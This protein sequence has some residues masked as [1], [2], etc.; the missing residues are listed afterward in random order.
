M[1]VFSKKSISQIEIIDETFR[2]AIE[3]SVVPVSLEDKM[4]ILLKMV[5]AGIKKF[6]MGIGPS[7]MDLLRRCVDLQKLGS[8]PNDVRFVYIVLLNT[9]EHTKAKFQKNFSRDEL[10][11]IVF[12]FGMLELDSENDLFSRVLDEYEAIGMDRRIARVSIL[13][14]F[15]LNGSKD[16]ENVEDILRQVQYCLK[17]D[18]STIR[19]NDSTGKLNPD[20]TVK[21]FTMLNKEFPQVGFGLHTHNDNGL[22]L[23]NALKSIE[24]GCTIV[25]GSLA[26]FGNR[27]GITDLFLLVKILKDLEYNIGKVDLQLLKEATIEAEKAFMLV[28]SVYRPGS[29]LYE[30]N[31]TTGV[32]NIPDYLDDSTVG[33]TYA[34]CADSLH[35][36]TIINALKIAEAPEEMIIFASHSDAFMSTLLNGV[37]FLFKEKGDAQKVQYQQWY[38]EM[39]NM[40]EGNAVFPRDILRVAQ[41]L[42]TESLTACN[43]GDD[44]YYSMGGLKYV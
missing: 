20:S 8:I 1:S 30:K 33:R 43:G 22:S 24:G 7:D 36:K 15:S 27:A 39:I 11:Q 26:G 29:G 23:I 32:L 38:A 13:N 9:W 17:N 10:N 18:I 37:E 40:Y 34:I 21:L 28:P 31:V 6:F 35:P 2:E 44:A 4:P 12:S 3:R 42:I 14:S 16:Q 5:D 41:L 19:I 25:E